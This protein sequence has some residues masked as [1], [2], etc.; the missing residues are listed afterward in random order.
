MPWI[1][2]VESAVLDRAWG[3]WHHTFMVSTRL[4]TWALRRGQKLA[5]AGKTDEALATF[6]SESASGNSRLLTQYALT[7]AQAGQADKALEQSA[8]AAATAPED[9]V[10][11]VFNACLLLRFGRLEAAETE[12][13]RARDLLPLNP[14]VPS[15][16]AALDI[17]RGKPVD[18]CTKLLEGP[19]TDNLDIL[20]WI[21]TVVERRI[22]EVAETN[23]GAIPP[24]D[25]RP[26]DDR[27]PDAVPELSA[28]ACSRKGQDL[29]EKGKPK[30]ALKYLARS[31]ELKPDDPAYHATYGAALFEAGEFERA[32]A[33]LERVPA[34]GPIGGVA[35]FYRAAAAYRLGEYE[36]ALHL[37]D[38]LPRKGDVV[39]YLEWCDYIRGMTLVALDRLPEAAKCLAAFIDTEPSLITRRLTKAL[40]LLGGDTSCSTSS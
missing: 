21:M 3:V 14:I 2:K 26:A 32:K 29:L 11:A 17:L 25:E 9:G 5:H 27:P 22:F 36:A 19:L 37:L 13:N 35:Q 4:A 23:S 15:L 18:G 39:L 6:E 7:L 34:K 28:G 24:E 38:T 10:P 30:S 31:T 1:V 33:E 12:L 8:A 16:S 40:E 20:G